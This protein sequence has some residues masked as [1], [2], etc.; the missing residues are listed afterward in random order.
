MSELDAKRE[1]REERAERKHRYRRLFLR[2]AVSTVATLSGTGWLLSE[3]GERNYP[4]VYRK[5]LPIPGLPDA[6]HG[7][8]ICQMSDFHRSWMVSEAH[9][10]RGAE[11]ANALKPDLTVLTGDFITDN[12]RYAE[13]CACALSTLQARHGVYGVLGNHDYWHGPEVVAREIEHA[14][15]RLLRNASVPL[16]TGNVDWWLCGVNDALADAVDLDAALRGVPK[17]AFHTLLCHEPNFA[18]RAAERGVPLQLSGHTHGG[19]VRIPGIPS[20]YP[21]GGGLYP[22]GLRKVRH[23]PS[24]VYTNVG[25]GVISI[26]IRIN[27]P[28]EV[29]L[30]TLVPTG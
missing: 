21:R 6:L 8:T 9:I 20:H 30:L 2:S 5:T 13:S 19:Q 12:S 4:Q 7:F 27:C 10:R 29:S 14:G 15:V 1:Q 24:L 16:R 18:N 23:S 25:L 17:G 26:P 22:I 3:F 11:M 28:P